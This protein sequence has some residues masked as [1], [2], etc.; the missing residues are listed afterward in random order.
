MEQGKIVVIGDEFALTGFKLGG[1][2]EGFLVNSSK[3][4]EDLL[5][6]LLSDK[7]IGIIIIID[8]LLEEMDWKTKRKIELSAR[9][10][11]VSIPSKDGPIE[12]EVSL[13]KLIKRA[14]GFDILNSDKK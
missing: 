14:L 8:K 10:I 7:S 2:K 12:E 11:I 9:P 4:A 6:K 1:V 3:E 13:A 5:N